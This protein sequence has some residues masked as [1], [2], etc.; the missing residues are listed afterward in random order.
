MATEC[1]ESTA[2]P[3]HAP[4]RPTSTGTRRRA[5]RRRT[6]NREPATAVDARPSAPP[7]PTRAA[8]GCRTRP[9]D[10]EMGGWTPVVAL[11]D[12]PDRKSVRVVIEGVDILVCRNGE[13]LYALANRCSHMG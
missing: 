8:R 13:V 2:S 4:A 9:V 3:A 7:P 1:R 6:W 5:A 11:A 12:L 10:T